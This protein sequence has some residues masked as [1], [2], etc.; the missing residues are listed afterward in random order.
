MSTT[1]KIIGSGQ[2]CGS[3]GGRISSYAQNP[4]SVLSTKETVS[5]RQEDKKKFKITVGHIGSSRLAW[6]TRDL[7][8]KK[9]GGGSKG[10]QGQPGI[11]R[12]CLKEEEGS[13]VAHWVNALAAKP[14]NL[15]SIPCHMIEG[16]NWLLPSDLNTGFPP[17]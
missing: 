6:D 13:N 1:F 11:L 16:E 4:E 2:G 3:V 17:T 14:D 15:S 9:E 7:V 12:P 5:Q 10:V 8:S